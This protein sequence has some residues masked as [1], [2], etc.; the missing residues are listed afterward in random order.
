M[1]IGRVL[2]TAAVLL[3]GGCATILG[4]EHN[5]GADAGT[6]AGGFDVA[7]ITHRDARARDAGTT[8]EAGGDAAMPPDAG[9]EDAPLCPRAF[10]AC[11]GRDAALC[12]DFDEGSSAAA[13]GTVATVGGGKVSLAKGLSVP[14]ALES[15]LPGSGIAAQAT[16]GNAI[17]ASANYNLRFVM[18]VGPCTLTEG[19]IAIA[20]LV[21]S[22]GST[23]TIYMFGADGGVAVSTA[24]SL[25]EVG[26]FS[27]P[28]GGGGWTAVELQVVV[29]KEEVL[30]VANLDYTSLLTT[31]ADAAVSDSSTLQIGQLAGQSRACTIR[32][33]DVTVDQG[34]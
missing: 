16:L 27:V 7:K 5:D 19:A 18:Q 32:I 20:T 10:C 8:P 24:P 21:S 33:D 15:R 4:L 26:A 30:T 17:G 25:S 6:D 2:V 31:P 12:L 3:V 11:L 9:G 13:F 23:A 14:N 29:G 34:N 1:S 22:T 28:I